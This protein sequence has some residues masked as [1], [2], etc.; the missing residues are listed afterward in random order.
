MTLESG[1]QAWLAHTS[2]SC[3]WEPFNLGVPYLDL[4]ES[5]MVRESHPKYAAWMHVRFAELITGHATSALAVETHLAPENIVQQGKP[6]SFGRLRHRAKELAA[7]FNADAAQSNWHGFLAGLVNK[8]I[9]KQ[10]IKRINDDRNDIAHGREARAVDEIR[11]DIASLLQLS[12][13]KALAQ[14]QE[15]LNYEDLSPWVVARPDAQTEAELAVRSVG[16]FEKWKPG[17][18]SYIVPWSGAYFLVN[19]DSDN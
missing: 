10:I 4:F 12:H 17:S 9:E 15:P 2:T 8:A 6:I 3:H 18:R 13:W 14:D 16:V 1:V 19:T 7:Q 11:E 5:Q